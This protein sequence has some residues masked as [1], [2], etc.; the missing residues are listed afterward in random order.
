MQSAANFARSIRASERIDLETCAPGVC[1]GH[2]RRMIFSKRGIS[3]CVVEVPA[4]VN[5]PSRRLVKRQSDGAPYFP[6]GR[7]IPALPASLKS[8]FHSSLLSLLFSSR[9]LNQDRSAINHN[10]LAGAVFLLHQK[11]VGLCNVMS[12]AD[13]S[14]RQTIAYAFKELLPFC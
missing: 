4:G 3:I 14:H 7:S 6:A 13:S 5:Q 11:Q 1:M 8:T 2:H 12:F 9:P 10:G